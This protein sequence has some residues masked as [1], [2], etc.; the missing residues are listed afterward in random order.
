MSVGALLGLR[1]VTD[2]LLPENNMK[3]QFPERNT[4]D[5]SSERID[6]GHDKE[7]ATVYG[8]LTPAYAVQE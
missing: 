5:T 4:W 6:Q 1:V 3:E 8:C 2:G 7:K